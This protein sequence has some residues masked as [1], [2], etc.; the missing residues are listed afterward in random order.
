MTPS[1]VEKCAKCHDTA[2]EME[3]VA[4]RDCHV[5]NPFS[6]EQ[7]AAKNADPLRYHIDQIGLKAAYH[8]GCIGCHEEMDGPTGCQDCHTR[9]ETGDAFYNAGEFAP[10]GKAQPAG[11]H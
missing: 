1:P 6:A 4:C 3:I 2:Q 5:K 8:Q 7:L 10:K 11:H 9:N